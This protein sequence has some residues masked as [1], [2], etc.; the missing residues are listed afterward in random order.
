MKQNNK[1][2][3]SL[4]SE[5]LAEAMET[6]EKWEKGEQAASTS[7][8]KKKTA[9]ASPKPINKKPNTKMEKPERK[10]LPCPVAHKCSGCQLQNMD[11]P[12]QLR[13]KQGKV[14]RLLGKF[15]KVCP[16]IGMDNPWHYRNKVQAAFGM[17]RDKKLFP[18]SGNPALTALYKL[19]TA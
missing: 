10:K 14:E 11:Y 12:E 9:T 7:P 16:I 5:I 18:A 1:Q 19:T 13:W 4:S 6:L 15:G 17:A 2:K 8:K 3:R